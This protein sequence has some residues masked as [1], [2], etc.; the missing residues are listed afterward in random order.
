MKL[1]RKTLKGLAIAAALSA[2]VLQLSGVL[3][4]RAADRL[5]RETLPEGSELRAVRWTWPAGVLLEDLTLPDPAEQVP[6]FF[7]VKRARFQ[8]PVW[9]LAIRPI[10]ARITFE[11]PHIVIHSGNLYP[12]VRGIGFRPQK[13]LPV[14]MWEMAEEE[15]ADPFSVSQESGLPTFPVAPMGLKIVDGRLDAGEEQIRKG[16][17]V[18]VADHI[19]LEVKIEALLQEPVL[20]LNGT[21][22]FV[23]D[24]GE[25]IGLQE[26]RA[27]LYPT[28]KSMQG[29][30]RLRHER[31]ADFKK[32]YQHAP[33]PILIENGMADAILDGEVT[34]AKHL[35]LMARCL[36]QNLDMVGN[37]GTDVTWAQI[38]HAVEDADRFYEW[39]VWMEGDITDPAFNPHDRIL[40]EV[41]YLMKEKAASR[42]LKI[43]GQMFFYADTPVPA[44]RPEPAEPE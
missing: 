43:P 21:G 42:G 44:D 30:L 41:E 24:E 25:P 37:V 6:F 19:N 3:L 26:M 5:I 17:P 15:G 31:L 9:G 12:L 16:K 4:S 38:M 20:T 35:K 39:K 23:S 27:R 28:R 8:V 22:Q 40:R 34:D 32:I 1:S 29:Y 2:V 11:S 10:P 14:P 18:F 33:A 7:K 13:W 36:V